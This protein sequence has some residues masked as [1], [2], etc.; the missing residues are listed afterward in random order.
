MRRL[1]DCPHCCGA[2]CPICHET[3]R[4]PEDVEVEY[5]PD[6]PEEYTGPMPECGGCYDAY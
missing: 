2:G 6:E 5:E 3:G 4:I 1:V